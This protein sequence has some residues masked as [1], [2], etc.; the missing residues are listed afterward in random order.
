MTSTSR[1]VAAMTWP[2]A[3]RCAPDAIL[4]IPL[5]STEQHGPH[6]PLSTDTDV[7]VGLCR[8]LAGARPDVLVAPALPYGASDEHAGFAGTLSI[9]REAMELVVVKLARSACATFGRVLLVSAHGGNAE[10]V[11][12]AVAR[13]RA[14]GREVRVH[15]PRWHEDPHAGHVETSLQLALEPERVRMDLAAPGDPRPLVE[16]M[17]LLRASGVRAVSP[18]GVLGDPTTA[19]VAAG[20]ELWRVLTAALLA[21]VAR[22]WPQPAGAHR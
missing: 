16:L 5:G 22:W 11:G 3:G 15:E 10:S 21:D 17:P 6:L 8:A 2:E 4:A 12:Q 20:R 9:G 7:A 14:E 13:L 1:L 18:S 19:T